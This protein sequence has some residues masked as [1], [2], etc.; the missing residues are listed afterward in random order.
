MKRSNPAHHDREKGRI[1][2]LKD[3]VVSLFLKVFLV[4]LVGW[5]TG[6]WADRN[7]DHKGT[8]PPSPDEKGAQYP[9]I[10]RFFDSFD[11]GKQPDEKSREEIKKFIKELKVVHLTYSIMIDQLEEMV[12]K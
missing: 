3:K 8:Y 9:E 6:S 4:L 10:V 12:K 11:K 7:G 2:T 5:N 1:G